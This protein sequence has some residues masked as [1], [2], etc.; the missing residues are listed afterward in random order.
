MNILK[1]EVDINSSIVS[2]IELK[3][4]YLQTKLYSKFN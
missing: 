3:N 1:L 4:S 2:T